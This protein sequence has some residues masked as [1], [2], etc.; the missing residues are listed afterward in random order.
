MH[1]SI[2][3]VTF[4]PTG[5]T[6]EGLAEIRRDKGQVPILTGWD[7]K[8][9]GPSLTVV[10]DQDGKSV[11]ITGVSR[12]RRFAAQDRKGPVAALD[13]RGVVLAYLD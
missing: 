5:K 6:A 10:G 1:P 13:V 4:T 11:R 3:N 8:R 9:S 7:V 12:V 2:K